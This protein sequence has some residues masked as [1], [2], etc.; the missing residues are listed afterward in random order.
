MK[1]RIQL[2]AALLVGCVFAILI[3]DRPGQRLR[4]LV[5]ILRSKA[6]APPALVQERNNRCRVCPI[7]YKPL[8]TCGSPLDPSLEA[9]GCWCQ[10]ETKNRF[11]LSDCWLRANTNGEHGWPKDL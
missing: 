9:L 5:N 8:G 11:L 7:Y 4:G 3:W 6:K 10:T 1:R 2:V